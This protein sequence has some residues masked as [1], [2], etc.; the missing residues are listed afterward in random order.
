MKTLPE[1]L[2]YIGLMMTDLRGTWGHNYKERIELVI[3]QIELSL[4]MS[5]LDKETKQKLEITFNISLRELQNIEMNEEDGRIFRDSSPLFSY[6]DEANGLT[7]DVSDRI[8][9]DMV[10]PENCFLTDMD[11]TVF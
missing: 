1:K 2:T 3:E 5:D 7:Q 8:Q 6:S 9:K 11:L 4:K 10:Y